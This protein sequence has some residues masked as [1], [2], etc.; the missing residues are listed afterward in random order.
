MKLLVWLH[1]LLDAEIICQNQVG[2]MAEFTRTLLER[3][4][5]RVNLETA[6]IWLSASRM[7]LMKLSGIQLHQINVSFG[8]LYV[9]SHKFRPLIAYWQFGHPPPR[10]QINVAIELLLFLKNR[11]VENLEL[12]KTLNEM[13]LLTYDVLHLAQGNSHIPSTPELDF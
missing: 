7:S 10:S 2:N 9:R 5:N 6:M 4:G 3:C 11:Q 12:K 8:D 1:F 13:I